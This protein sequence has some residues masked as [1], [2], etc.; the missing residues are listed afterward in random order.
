MAAKTD[1]TTSADSRTGRRNIPAR[2]A[3]DEVLW[4]AW[5]Y[6]EQGQK[7]EQIADQLGISRAS[8]FNLLQKA[9]DEGIVKISIDPSRIARAD[10][11]QALCEATGLAECYILPSPADPADLY[12]EIGHLG[13]RVLEARL[14]AEDTIGVAWGRT[15]L[16]LSHHL[17]S[18]P[19]P[20]VTVAQITGSAAATFD[21]SPV[22]CTSTIAERLA[23]RCVNLH[24]PG[25]VSSA[26]VK[27]ILMAEPEIRHHFELLRD[28]TKTIFGVTQL[29]G[30]TLLVQASFMSEAELAGYRDLGAVGFAAGYFFNA[31]G[32]I[33]RN[34]FDARH[35]TMDLE[36]LL[37]VPERICVGAGAEKI[38][39]IA[40]MLKARLATI[41]ITDEATAQSLLDA[42]RSGATQ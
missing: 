22:L 19:R 38:G 5:L 7:Q 2:F 21:F 40:G 29:T 42:H 12:D 17:Q 18:M 30:E 24:A 34:A 16:S 10:L 33:V 41:L 1:K 3:M 15:V 6:Y 9:R 8:V 28:C 20:S 39:A 36:D 4:A 11:S 25:V 37:D 13:A 26:H 27:D 23:A 14:S 31:E 32:H 35:I